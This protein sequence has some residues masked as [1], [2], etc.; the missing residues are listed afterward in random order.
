MCYPYGSYSTDTLAILKEKN[1]IAGLTTAEYANFKTE[2]VLELSRFDT[3]D[4]RNDA[5]AKDNKEVCEHANILMSLSN[6]C[7]IYFKARLV[8]LVWQIY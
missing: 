1:C 5:Q 7:L 8:Q 2:D 3:N 4:F 6:R